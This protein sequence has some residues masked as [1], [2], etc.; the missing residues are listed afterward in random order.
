VFSARYFFNQP[1]C[2]SLLLHA[3]ISVKTQHRKKASYLSFT[4]Y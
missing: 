1:V 3:A 4:F 2:Y